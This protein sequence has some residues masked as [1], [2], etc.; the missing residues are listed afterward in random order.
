MGSRVL[1]AAA[2][3][4]SWIGAWIRWHGHGAVAGA[5]PGR[6]RPWRAEGGEAGG[7]ACKLADANIN[8]EGVLPISICGGE[9]IFA[10]CVDEADEA[11]RILGEQVV[12]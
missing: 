12:G 5:D 4:V 8:V 10:T 2:N 11:R 1:A 3:G 9:V 7:F 6:H